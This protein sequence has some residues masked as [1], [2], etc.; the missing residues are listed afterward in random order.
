M[1]LWGYSIPKAR[2]IDYDQNDRRLA[3]LLYTTTSSLK[4]CIE[5]GGCTATCS[6]G[7]FTKLNFRR[8][9]TLI[10]RG[11]YDEAKTTLNR[12]M[13]CGKCLL[14]CPRG[15]DTRKVILEIM[16]NLIK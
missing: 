9:H 12:C 5:C 1:N 4:R 10:R 2:A 3:E 8:I 11:E 13:L 6:A 15:V 14:I 7:T 16:Q